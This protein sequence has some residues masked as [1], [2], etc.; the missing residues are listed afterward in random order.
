VKTLQHP[1]NTTLSAWCDGEIDADL[2]RELRQHLSSCA[3]CSAE[4]EGFRG[5]RRSLRE[6]SR[7]TPPDELQYRLRIALAAQRAGEHQGLAPWWRRSR[8]LFYPSALA[9]AGGWVLAVVFLLVSSVPVRG[10]EDGG[11][12]RKRSEEWRR[13][14]RYE[15]LLD[16]QPP[17]GARVEV[18]AR[19]GSS[20]GGIR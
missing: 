11:T 10:F 15:A 13:L 6:L 12:A 1:D 18:P 8:W 2:A 5:V 17:A 3:R 7:P 9:G 16:A 14:E 19:P 20:R 4:V